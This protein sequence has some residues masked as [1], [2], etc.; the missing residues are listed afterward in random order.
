MVTGKSTWT[1]IVL[2]SWCCCNKLPQTGGLQEKLILS[3][4]EKPKV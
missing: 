2:V 3:Q 1:L 4:F